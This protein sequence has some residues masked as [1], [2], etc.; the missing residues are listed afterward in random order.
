MFQHAN[1]RFFHT[2]CTP[3]QN[4][5]PPSIN[6]H[7]ELPYYNTQILYIYSNH[8]IKLPL[9]TSRLFSELVFSRLSLCS[10]PSYTEYN[11]PNCSHI[12]NYVVQK[13]HFRVKQ[14]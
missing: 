9:P 1:I 4:P 5:T 8:K 10:F 11:I 13:G 2:M 3:T 14:M 7:T 6:S 12:V